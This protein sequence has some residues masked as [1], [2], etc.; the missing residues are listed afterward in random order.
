[1]IILII[2]GV[3]AFGNSNFLHSQFDEKTEDECSER[4]AKKRINQN[5]FVKNKLFFRK[6]RRFLHSMSV[7]R[8]VA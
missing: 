2:I 8:T 7:K 5:N 1:V 6:N 3:L 4:L